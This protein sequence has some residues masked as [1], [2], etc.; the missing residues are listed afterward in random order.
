MKIVLT[1]DIPNVGEE[2]DVKVVAN[3][4]ARNYLI[5]KKMVIPFNKHSLDILKQKQSA[6]D[7]RKEEKRRQAMG[8]KERLETE[9][10]VFKMPAGDSGKLFGSINNANI[11]DELEKRGYS[12]EK[13]RI[14]V[15][16]HTIKMVG[17]FSVNIKLY[18]NQEA[19]L[20]FE[21]QKT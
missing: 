18:E 12:I 5:P 20:K 10:I 14:D 8:L 7:K 15:A 11:A 16:D 19:T 17:N 21:V 1:Q 3:G 4:Y 6:I 2:G 13:K 9:E